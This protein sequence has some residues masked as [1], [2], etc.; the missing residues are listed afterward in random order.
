[1]KGSIRYSEHISG[2]R[3]RN[4]SKR[5]KL[6]I[7]RDMELGPLKSIIIDCRPI[8]VPM[9]TIVERFGEASKPLSQ[10]ELGC[11]CM[12]CFDKYLNEALQRSEDA[13]NQGGI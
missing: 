1:M 5:S 7:V 2:L 13:T 8:S 4:T 3:P 10:C 11:R 9:A 12:A 6:D